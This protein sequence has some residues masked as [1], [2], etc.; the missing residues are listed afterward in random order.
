MKIQADQVT[1]QELA[2][3]GVDES[4]GV[5]GSHHVQI[6]KG[7]PIRLDEIK[8]AKVPSAG[9]RTATKIARGRA[10]I[11]QT[12]TD[13]LKTLAATGPLDAGK[14]LGLL[15]AQ[16][17]H[18]ER[19]DKLGQLDPAQKQDGEG[20]W[21]FTKAIEKLSNNELSAIF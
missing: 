1:M 12:A 6:G 8:S 5:F 21:M 17:T 7:S 18:M 4:V 14:L 3:R 2:A 11:E 13:A 20:L 16:Q 9:F 10:G 15:K 19:L